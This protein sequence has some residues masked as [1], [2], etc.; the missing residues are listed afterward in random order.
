M[1]RAA[2]IQLPLL[3]KVAGVMSSDPE[4]SPM[5]RSHWSIHW[6]PLLWWG[7]L[8]ALYGLLSYWANQGMDTDKQVVGI[9]ALLNLAWIGPLVWLLFHWQ[10]IRR[11]NRGSKWA[12]RI[13][14]VVLAVVGFRSIDVDY[15]GD[16][17]WRAIRF[18][19]S[20]DP[21]EQ[22][23]S[24]DA[25]SVAE[26]WQSTPND[27]PRFLGEGYWAEVSDV[28][29]AGD[30][31]ANPPELLWK[32]PIGAGWSAFAVVGDYAVTQE[33][34]GEDE[35]V[36]CYR[37]SDGSVV[38]THA[39]AAR[40]DP[41]TM[42]GGLGGV[43]PR[44]TPTIHDGRVY[45]MGATGIVNCLD[46]RT[47]AA[48]WT[49]NLPEEYD[50]APLYWANSGSPL[51]VPT[52]NIVVI[53]GGSNSDE[54]LD[55][56]ERHSILAFD[57]DNG[58]LVWQAGPPTTSYASPVYAEIA[59]T[60]QVVQVNEATVGGYSVN[61][62]AELWQHEQPGSSAANASCSQPI[63][64]PDDRILV[65]KGYSIGARLLQ[66]EPAE[67]GRQTATRLWKKT[68]LKTKLANLVVRDGYAYG[69]DHTL[70]SCVE[71]ETG[72]VQWKKR[73]RGSLGHGQILLVGE[74]LFVLSETG[75]GVLLECNP[76]KY[77]ELT[78]MQ[79]LTDEGINWNNPALSGSH[80]LLRNNLEAACYR[81]PTLEE[82][83]TSEGSN[84]TG[85]TP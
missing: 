80:L 79:M 16:S 28:R 10:P 13:G 48:V 81:L 55:E 63:P 74:H 18:S 85:E 37:V 46:A 53:N 3:Y 9:I 8:L 69:L 1:L 20:A 40:H 57:R 39:D 33:Q 21:D 68:V 65:C 73:R 60:P 59:G 67:G 76:N 75:E 27:Y 25:A 52:A 14:A 31:Q 7:L 4:S 82:P 56:Q 22:L 71:I 49:H 51:V 19:W 62:G 24:L 12:L 26:N 11:L 36:V 29:L 61:D 42:A 58:D 64:L 38:W 44:A 50:I 77:V 72:K 15:D 41:A 34:R 43:G 54:S 23:D 84:P 45:T 5:N 66:I 6:F 35:L 17:R 2:S 70:M 30:W 83:L 47:G 78:A 32:Q